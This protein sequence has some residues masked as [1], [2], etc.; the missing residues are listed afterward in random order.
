MHKIIM[1]LRILIAA[2]GLCN[3]HLLLLPER[4]QSCEVLCSFW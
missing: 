4:T 2:K 1:F 3:R